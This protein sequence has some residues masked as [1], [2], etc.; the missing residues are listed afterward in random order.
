MMQL[1]EWEA[2][3]S[4]VRKHYGQGASVGG[5]NQPDIAK[6]VKLAAQIDVR[7]A[8]SRGGCRSTMGERLAHRDLCQHADAAAIIGSRAAVCH[9]GLSWSLF[10]SEATYSLAS[11]RVRSSRP[12]WSAIGGAGS[13]SVICSPSRSG[14]SSQPQVETLGELIYSDSKLL[15]REQNHRR[16]QFLT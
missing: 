12:S 11:R 16:Y 14:V 2:L 1:A 15:V 7:K 9:C 8:R 5:Y 6:L 10:G 13:W 3:A 4:R